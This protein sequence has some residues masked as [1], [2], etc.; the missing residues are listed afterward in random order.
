MKRILLLEDH[1]LSGELLRTRLEQEGWVVNWVETVADALALCDSKHPDLCIIDRVLPDGDGIEVVESVRACSDH[2]KIL[3]F[4]K[5]GESSS[6]IV[7]LTSGADDY[8]SKPCSHQEIVLRC[9]RLL[10]VTRTPTYEELTAQGTLFVPSNGVLTVADKNISLRKRESQ[11]LECLLRRK[12][13]V[14]SRDSLIRSVW[15]TQE[16][17]MDSTIDVYIR[18]LRMSVKDTLT[19]E[20][21][22][23]FGYRVKD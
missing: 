18:R 6:R 20:T 13:A 19:I 21:I 15:G 23:G 1:K 9:K 11:I 5:E 16:S 2:T 22:R 12:N 3:I 10:G 4:S 14:V 7:G 8:V 17:P